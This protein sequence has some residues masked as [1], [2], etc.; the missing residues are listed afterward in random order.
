MTATIIPDMLD[1]EA[2]DAAQLVLMN[3]N[4]YKFTLIGAGGNGSYIAPELVRY[5]KVL[6]EMGS[7]AEAVFI[8]PDTV[9]HKNTYR[10]NFCPA[11]VGQPKALALATRLGFAWGMEIPAIIAKFEPDMISRRSDCINILVG[12]VD[13]P[14]GRASIHEALRQ[15]NLWCGSHAPTSWHLDCGNGFRCGT[16]RIGSATHPEMLRHAFPAETI[17]QSLPAPALQEPELLVPKSGEERK[18]ELSCA[19]LLFSGEQSM[20]INKTVAALAADYL[21]QLTISK[22]LNRCATFVDLATGVMSSE[23]ITPRRIAA[24]IDSPLDFVLAP[25]PDEGGIECAA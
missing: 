23:Y 5:V 12:C 19:E 9:E 6:R 4:Y 22:E 1:F 11:E 2:A 20:T 10:Q 8:D 15:Q 21:Y 13:N 17:C 24:M 16:V 14:E 25:E 18:K 3:C 7:R